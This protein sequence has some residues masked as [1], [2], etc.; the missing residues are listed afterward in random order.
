MRKRG[1]IRFTVEGSGDFPFDM[2]RYDHCWPEGE[3][4]SYK[5]SLTYAN[6][7]SR[8]DDTYPGL[9]RVTLQSDSPHAPTEGRWRSFTW[10]VLPGS[11]ETVV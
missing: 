2:L 11:V 4:E 10:R 5:I 1:R 3:A 8:E 6:C 7:N 9:R